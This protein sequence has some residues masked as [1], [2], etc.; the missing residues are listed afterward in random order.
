MMVHVSVGVAASMLGVAVS[1]L[2]RWH[3]EGLLQ[4]AFRTPGGHRR[5]SIQSLQAFLEPNSNSDARRVCCYAR[6][7]SHD[8]RDDLARQ[9]RRLLEYC[10]ARGISH[11][12]II[13]DLGSGLNYRKKGIRQLIRLIALGQLSELIVV[14]R[15]RLLRFGA[16]IL[17]ELCA[18]NGTRVTVIESTQ[19]VS[20]EQQL[21]LDVIELMTVFSARL[22]GARSHRN[23]RAYLSN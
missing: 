21:S 9:S 5:Y 16:E 10:S 22:Y 7:S 14:H 15:D 8:Q 17:F 18:L 11:P 13:E 23:R 19:S 4:P 2:R 6:V 12:R 1:T 20:R 3:S